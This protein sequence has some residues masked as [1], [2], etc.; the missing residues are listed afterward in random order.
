[1]QP[2]LEVIRVKIFGSGHV[3]FGAFD[4][5]GVVCLVD[6]VEILQPVRILEEWFKLEVMNFV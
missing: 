3:F 2:S 5:F 4:V 6:F 1:M